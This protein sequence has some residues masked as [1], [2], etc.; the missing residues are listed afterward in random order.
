MLSDIFQ[1][2]T[3]KSD[4]CMNKELSKIQNYCIIKKMVR[5]LIFCTLI[6]CIPY[7]S[8]IRVVVI[9]TLKLL[10]RVLEEFMTRWISYRDYMVKCKVYNIQISYKLQIFCIYLLLK[11]CVDYLPDCVG[12]FSM[13]SRD[14]IFAK[15]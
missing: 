10:P 6:L 3:I 7:K 15:L 2:K 8:D 5:D 4:A 9:E 11:S 12:S 13:D 14:L 1:N